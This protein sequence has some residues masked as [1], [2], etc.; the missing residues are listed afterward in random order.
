MLVAAAQVL[1]HILQTIEFL[2]PGIE[3]LLKRLI[4]LRQIPF[5]R[6]D[7]RFEPADQILNR[8]DGEE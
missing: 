1:H 6:L 3:V 5:H 7:A 2:D 8:L 4:F